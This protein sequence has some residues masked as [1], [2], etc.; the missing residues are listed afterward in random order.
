MSLTSADFDVWV[1][2]KT[3]K[4]VNSCIWDHLMFFEIDVPDLFETRCIIEVFDKN[5][6]TRNVIIG[7][8]VHTHTQS[9]SLCSVVVMTCV[10]L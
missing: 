7:V 6:I 1:Q 9:L 8:Y 2:T 4:R 5:V 10:Y 3:V